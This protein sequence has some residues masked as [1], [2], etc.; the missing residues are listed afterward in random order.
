MQAL[1]SAGLPSVGEAFPANWK[2]RIYQANPSGFYESDLRHGIHSKT[3]PHPVTGVR[4]SPDQVSGVAVKVFIPGLIKT[5]AEYIGRVV[6]TVRPW[7]EYEAS[8]GRLYKMEDAALPV[9]STPI[10]RM[11]S[12]LEWWDENSSM[13][14]DIYMRR[15]SVNVVSYDN[16]FDDPEKIIGE[17]I[18]W[19]GLEMDVDAAV[20]TVNPKHRTQKDVES[21]SFEGK[22]AAVCDELYEYIHRRKGIPK[23]FL[24]KMSETDKL[25]RPLIR[26]DYI[27]VRSERAA[28]I[29]RALDKCGEP[30]K[31]SAEQSSPYV[32]AHRLDS[33]SVPRD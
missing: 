31:R 4:F 28:L 9:G 19:I 13:I 25:I 14:H 3:N 7:R 12:H 6:A 2:E 18:K 16:V 30:S 15:Y 27:R 24:D 1:T 8:I 23:P 21:N 32:D 5:D 22:L 33:V 10:P 17:T 20:K 26:E 11:K 29:D